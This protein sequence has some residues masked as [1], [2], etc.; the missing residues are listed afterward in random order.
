MLYIFLVLNIVPPFQYHIEEKVY[1]CNVKCTFT[2][3]TKSP[4]FIISLVIN[5]IYNNIKMRISYGSLRQEKSRVVKKLCFLLSNHSSISS[6][7]F[8]GLFLNIST[9]I[10]HLGHGRFVFKIC[11]WIFLIRIAFNSRITCKWLCIQ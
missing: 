11:T 2:T 1:T 3:F 5:T 6:T 7:Y 4:P 9:S 10:W 8:F